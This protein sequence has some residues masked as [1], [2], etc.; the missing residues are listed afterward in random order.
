MKLPLLGVAAVVALGYAVP[1]EASVSLSLSNT[2]Q[3][4]D[5]GSECFV[6]AGTGGGGA[7]IGGGARAGAGAIVNAGGA[8]AG[9]AGAGGVVGAGLNGGAA[10][11]VGASGLGTNGRANVQATEPAAVLLAAAALA[12]LGRRRTAD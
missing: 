7:G 9:A 1:A 6:S 4:S 11:G 12:L 5:A 8:G 10:A 3:R 2:I